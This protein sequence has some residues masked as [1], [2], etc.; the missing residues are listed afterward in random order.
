MTTKNLALNEF[1]SCQPF[2]FLGNSE[3]V[4]FEHVFTIL[5]GAGGQQ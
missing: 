3:Y 4:A 2:F 1:S 5:A